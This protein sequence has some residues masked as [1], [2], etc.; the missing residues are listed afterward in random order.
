MMMHAE[1]QFRIRDMVDVVMVV[2]G[3]VEYSTYCLTNVAQR[4]DDY[5]ELTASTRVD[6]A[7]I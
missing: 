5:R 4:Y 7:P 3:L 6:G 1:T 2:V